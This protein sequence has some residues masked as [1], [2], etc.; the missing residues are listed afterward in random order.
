LF[1]KAIVQSGYTSSASLTDAY[2]EGGENTRV[3][4][5]GWQL[6]DA[7]SHKLERQADN[8]PV[9]AA[10][11]RSLPGETVLQLYNELPSIGYVPL[12]TSDD[13]VIPAEGMLAALASPE[14][15]KQIPVIAGANRDEVTLWLGLHRYFVDANYPL[16]RLLPPRLQLKDEDLYKY[17]VGVRS[18]AWK[19][20]GVD[21]PLAALEAAGYKSLYAYRFDWDDQQD[22]FFADFPALIGAAHGT[23]ISFL[24]GD[25]RYGP[26]T[27]YIYPQGSSRDQMEK[28][29]MGAWAGFAR[30]GRPG[31]VSSVVWEPYTLPTRRFMHLDTDVN[32]RLASET[33][34]LDSLL[35]QVA[36]RQ[37]LSH[38][39]Q[40]LLVW[41]SLTKVGEP[42]Y[43]A[44]NVWN[45]GQCADVDASHEQ[46]LID[47]RLR[48][49][50]G[51][52]KV[53]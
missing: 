49:K 36:G 40:C 19:L 33:A 1:H 16:T 37:Q 39:Q 51:S 30:D 35:S 9:T 13:V 14:N 34:T 21:A 47:E 26:I 7:L 2:N 53:L 6:A 41:D 24:T 38:L 46:V 52:E 25:Y 44:Y 50:Y 20:R 43:A 28:T 4:R 22:S 29:M 5:S 45:R 32:L 17:W 10:D 48:E 42:D 18:S 11:L 12:T 31:S 27:D 23:D 15:A 3:S 8:S